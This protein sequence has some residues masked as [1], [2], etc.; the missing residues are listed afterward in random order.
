MACWRI[1][2]QSDQNRSDFC[3]LARAV[4]TRAKNSGG[5][6]LEASSARAMAASVNSSPRS[7]IKYSRYSGST[8]KSCRKFC[9]LGSV[10][11]SIQ[12]VS[13]IGCMPSSS[14]IRCLTRWSRIIMLSSSRQVFASSNFIALPPHYPLLPKIYR[15]AFLAFMITVL[16][17]HV[18][19]NG[20]SL[21]VAL[22]VD[23][24]NILQGDAVIQ[25]GDSDHDR[26]TK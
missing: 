19:A 12:R 5:I 1:R 18:N 24:V 22:S 25:E 15:Y 9:C 10:P 21:R 14:R 11:S 4:R 23:Q 3:V 7:E 8:F 17:V 16:L 13:V 20:A 6:S 2:L 26:F